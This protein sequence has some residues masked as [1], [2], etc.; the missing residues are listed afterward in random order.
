ME[1][2]VNV[3]CD[4]RGVKRIDHSVGK[5]WVQKYEHVVSQHRKYEPERLSHDVS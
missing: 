3:I 1:R 4:Y 5:A 2:S